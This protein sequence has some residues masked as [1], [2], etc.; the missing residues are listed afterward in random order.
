MAK[1]S[2]KANPTFTAMVPIPVAGSEAT[3]VQFTFRHRTR[4]ELDKYLDEI[5]ALDAEGVDNDVSIVMKVAT[6][7]ELDD[8]FTQ[9]NVLEL[10]SN[11]HGSGY[12]ISRSYV[13]ELLAAKLGN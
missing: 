13:R 1:L 4:Q 6:G 9:E 5:K 12:A 11:Y 2:L 10:V 7:W 8:P 3:M